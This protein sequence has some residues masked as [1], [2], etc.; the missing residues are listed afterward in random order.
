MKLDLSQVTFS[1]RG[2]YLALCMLP[3]N[4]GGGDNEAGLFLKTLRGAA[5]D[6]MICRL[7]V[8]ADGEPV[9]YTYEASPS[10]LVL[11]ARDGVVRV[12]FAS[13]NT[14]LF[15][16]EDG[17]VGLRFDNVSFRYAH[18]VHYAENTYQMLVSGSNQ[19]RYLVFARQGRVAAAQDWNGRSAQGDMTVDFLPEN[20][21]FF[22]S[23]EEVEVEW[24]Q[25]EYSFDYDACR[26]SAARDFDAFYRSMPQVP[27]EYEAARELA[28][29]VNWSSVV[30]ASGGFGRDAM[31]MSKNR[32]AALWSWDHCFNALALSYGNQEAAWDQFMLPFDRQD[33]S[34]RVPDCM[35]D[36][37]ESS[38]YCKPPVHG[39]TLSKMMERMELTSAQMGEAYEKLSKLTDW[40]LDCR[41]G[42]GDG[43]CEYWHGND[44]G[45]DNS[46]V[47]R[48]LP[49]AETPDL[50]A[51]LVIQMDVLSDLAKRLDLPHEAA[52]WKRRADAMLAAMVEHCYDD[53]M[54]VARRSG[55]HEPILSDSL[56]LHIP[57]VLGRRMPE[58][59]FTRTVDILK[60]TK[61]LTEHGLATEAPGSEFYQSDGYWRGPI[62]APSTMLIVDGLVRGGETAF[63]KDI[64]RRFCGMAAKSGCAENFDA[65]SGESLCD[66][67]YTWTASVFLLLAN[68]LL[69]EN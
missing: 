49:P 62:W 48:V 6:M 63:A 19:C 35:T 1:L 16:G 27:S 11:S 36:S 21:G 25:R 12:C 34:G 56:L 45:W 54:P 55:S 13:D 26:D 66:P 40:W 5:H 24:R 30:K 9:P 50:A 14:L 61:F 57:V 47:F 43:I 10:E 64:A 18:E 65:L 41:D 28:A 29:Y 17:R 69:D 37:G 3:K 60:S 68:F 46:T 7:T 67:A 33:I 2:S 51:F 38:L 44:S 8:L 52:G 53:D 32:M 4:H 15:R 58:P 23:L 22:C 42:D 20:G 31:L 59:L 39:W